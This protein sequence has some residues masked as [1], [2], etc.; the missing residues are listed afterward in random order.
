MTK[1]GVPEQFWMTDKSPAAM[2]VLEWRFLSSETLEFDA[3]CRVIGLRGCIS[4]KKY[5]DL[6]IEVSSNAFCATF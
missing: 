6:S 2:P 4:M 1:R 5:L 3:Y